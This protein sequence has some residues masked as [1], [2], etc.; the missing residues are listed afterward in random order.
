MT[1]STS[2]VL[3]PLLSNSQSDIVNEDDWLLRNEVLS[4]E[5]SEINPKVDEGSSQANVWEY[6]PTL[7]QKSQSH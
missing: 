3:Q 6:P 2:F 5:A 4:L 1:G 7:T